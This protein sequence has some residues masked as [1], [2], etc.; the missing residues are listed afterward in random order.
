VFNVQAGIPIIYELVETK[1]WV[2]KIVCSS[3]GMVQ[4][5][6]IIE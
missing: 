1:S 6:I 4:W 2:H 3:M 5:A